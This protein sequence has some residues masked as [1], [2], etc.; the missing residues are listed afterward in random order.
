MA[1]TS[2]GN[3]NVSEKQVEV[4]VAPIE[5][6]PL[7]AADTLVAALAGNCLAELKAKLGEAGVKKS[8][9]ALIIRYTMEVVEKT[10]LKGAAQKDFALRLIGDL[11][12]ELPDGDEK[13]FLSDMIA[14]GGIADTIDLVVS[15]TKGDLDVNKVAKVAATSCLSGCLSFLKRRRE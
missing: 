15:A 2:E 5:T 11:V 4:E 13:A 1:Q 14:S 9:V 3:G 8:T 6:T 12:A 7:A 10:P